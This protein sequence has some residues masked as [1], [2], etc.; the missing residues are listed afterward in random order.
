MSCDELI[1]A[2]L[3]VALF[4][5]LF[6]GAIAVF[7]FDAVHGAYAGTTPAAPPDT[8]ATPPTT[9]PEMNNDV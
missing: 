1:R 4:G 5:L 3:V 8:S 7:V 9:T 6:A 2:V